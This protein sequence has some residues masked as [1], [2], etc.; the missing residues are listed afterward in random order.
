[1]RSDL[2][3]QPYPG[4]RPFER[5]ESSIFFG[6]DK[7]IDDL[8]MRLKE[9]HFLA[10]IGLS[11]SGKSSLIKAGLLP[12]LAKG[13]MGESGADWCIAEM[14][15][16]D[17]PIERLARAL[18]KNHHFLESW[19]KEEFLAAELRRGSRSINQI[20]KETNLPAK[21]NLLLVIDQF[22]EIF[23]FNEF[24]EELA[25]AFVAL[26]LEASLHKKIFV[27]ITMRSDF[28]GNA[29]EFQNLPESINKGLYLTPRLTRSQLD[30]AIRK[31]AM[32]FNG[33][34]EDSLINHLIN[35][36]GN[37]PDQLPLL[38]HALM[39][40]WGSNESKLLLLKDYKKL[41]GLKGALN[42][43]AE[44]AWNELDSYRKEYITELI[45]KALTESS[46]DGKGIRKPVKVKQLQEL[47]S[48][49]LEQI[50]KIIDV[51]RKEERNF[52]MPPPHEELKRNTI[53]DISHESLIRQ[54]E[55]LQKWVENENIKK[56]NYLRLLDSAHR[57]NSG[58]GELLY[59][60][61]LA[62]THEWYTKD[63]PNEAWAKRY[64]SRAS[65]FKVSINY[66]E[67]SDR[68]E[69]KRERDRLFKAELEKIKKKRKVTL[70]IILTV[71]ILAIIGILFNYFL[72]EH[73]SAVMQAENNVYE[74]AITSKPN[75]PEKYIDFARFMQYARKDFNKAESLYKK[76][77]NV[78]PNN[79]DTIMSYAFF[80]ENVRKN[81]IEA[82]ILYKEA[83]QKAPDDVKL[84]STYAVFLAERMKNFDK[85]EAL[86]NEAIR[87]D[88][89]NANIYGTY[90]AFL[91]SYR[92][93][94]I[95]AKAVYEMA[96]ALDENATCLGCYALFLDSDL[97]D[98]DEA[99]LYYNKA[100][101]AHP[102]QAENYSN[103]ARFKSNIRK[104]NISAENL[105]KKA[106]QTE[107]GSA[108]Y[109]SRYAVF[110]YESLKDTTR[111][112]YILEEALKAE[113][114]NAEV[115][116]TYAG[117]Q[118]SFHNNNLAKKF[119]E[120][121]MK[122][123]PNDA[124]T[125]LNYANFLARSLKDN[126]KA[127]ELYENAL[128]Q[129][130]KN[131]HILGHFATF[132]KEERQNNHRA[133]FLYEAAIKID[134]KATC[135]GCFALFMETIRE[136]YPRAEELYEQAIKADPENIFDLVNYA[137]F[138]SEI[139]KDSIKS[140]LLFKEAF[141]LDPK[142]ERAQKFYTMF[143]GGGKKKYNKLN[144]SEQLSLL[145]ETKKIQAINLGQYAFYIE[146]VEK[147]YKRAE[148][149]YREAID[150]DN[151]NLDNLYNYAVFLNESLKNTFTAESI[152]KSILIKSPNHRPTLIKYSKFVKENWN[153]LDKN[154]SL[155]LKILEND[156]HDIRF[157]IDLAETQFQLGNIK[158]GSKVVDQILLLEEKSKTSMDPKLKIKLFLLKFSY[159]PLKYP[160]AAKKIEGLLGAGIRNKNLEIERN[161]HNAKLKNHP[162]IILLE[163][164]YKKSIGYNY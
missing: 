89:G 131:P 155:I 54:W 111:A 27:V 161:L 87:I 144:F 139:K 51:F 24:D 138:M 128:K 45:F 72:S 48:T 163:Q 31:P 112:K 107:P 123:D 82:E 49:S 37:D 130:P 136:N 95:K 117:F 13:Y 15:P 1:M 40:L 8:L 121:S 156:P 39:R 77:I 68:A 146:K 109:K 18:L 2:I 59:G 73:N 141:K 145:K 105:H 57:Y 79:A 25:A 46:F 125:L 81:Y 35:E 3:K 99:E 160:N 126:D 134:P 56:N 42:D 20:F 84:L 102:D 38:Q 34:I 63:I 19:H 16:S 5:S 33:E 83:V 135:L 97:K 53:I 80:M 75:D 12:A 158:E 96:L 7:Q 62:V 142:N 6:R 78:D 100:I 129:Y 140:E 154:K 114:N 91:K 164:L 65:D 14:R 28:L 88:S 55:R 70:I 93:D 157:L 23:R 58:T 43:H 74:V 106:I 30:E 4:L 110:I 133:E 66:Y 159:L 50:T 41:N 101:K 108:E 132:L 64:S 52:L 119:F 122:V 21:E 118:I 98:Y 44:Q 90:A 127:E 143:K 151:D 69:K 29:A 94:F 9:H 10:V 71:A 103:F 92:G 115:L 153:N 148:P 104:D 86:F 22:E 120:K 162:S 113:P 11:G 124:T 76:A 60:T 149:L 32:I 137:A 61:D 67:A 47:T 85:P 17:Q 152:F 150:L 147:N 36:V 26:I 116:T